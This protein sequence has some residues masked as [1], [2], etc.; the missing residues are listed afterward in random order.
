MRVCAYSDLKFVG[1]ELLLDGC[2]PALLSELEEKKITERV[3]G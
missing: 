3:K 2:E 1:V